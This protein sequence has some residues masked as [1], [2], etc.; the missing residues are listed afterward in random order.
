MDELIIRLYNLPLMKK[1]AIQELHGIIT[2]IIYDGSVDD[3]EMNLL[4][5]WI[6][7]NEIVREEWPVSRLIDI[8]KKIFNDGE[9]TAAE[10]LELLDFL[11]GIA[12]ASPDNSPVATGIFT[13][14]P[15][16][17]IPE[18][19]FLFSGEMKFGERKRAESVVQKKGGICC[20]RY[21]RIVDYLVVG[22][23]GQ[24]AWKYARYGTKI[25]ACMKAKSKGLAKTEIVKE[26]DFVKAAINT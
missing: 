11:Q 3:N 18:H 14:N 15:I 16:I 23:L 7:K 22:D 19:Y 9:I 1:R 8:L 5:D 24:E 13:D 6:E 12:S 25:E 2:A 4:V 26:Y 21:S 17:S 20:P 10:R